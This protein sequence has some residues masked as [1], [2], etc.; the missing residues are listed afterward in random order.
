MSGPVSRLG[1]LRGKGVDEDCVGIHSE[2]I[3]LE[4]V[5]ADSTSVMYDG[6]VTQTFPYKLC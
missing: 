5:S 1:L 2:V 6:L 3:H 4:P